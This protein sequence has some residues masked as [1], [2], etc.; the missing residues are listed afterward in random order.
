MK[1]S[2]LLGKGLLKVKKYSPEILLGTGI[3][4]MVGT[5]VV[6]CKA[7]TKLEAVTTEIAAEKEAFEEKLKA[8]EEV[9]AEG[10]EVDYTEADKKK[11]LL[12]VNTQQT[13]KLVKLYAPA[14]IL[15]AASIACILASYGIMKKRYLGVLAAYKSLD[16][17][18]K[19]YKAKV[20]AKYGEEAE[21]E[22]RRT[23]LEDIIKEGEEKGYEGNPKKH[24]VYSPYSR[25]Y[26]ETCTC[27]TDDFE[28]NRAFLH[29]TQCQMN[30][31]LKSQG[32]LYLN[33]VYDALGLA[34]SKEGA[35]VGWIL[36]GEGDSFVDFGVF[37]GNSSVTRAFVNGWEHSIL[38]DFN[39]DGVIYD[40]I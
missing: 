13:M 1:F 4:G 15:G 12:I 34:R 3:V 37:D 21:A 25:F 20:V 28:Y 30:N 10:R 18:F 24:N 36:D 29:T 16:A 11:D 23:S 33:E 8:I 26:D 5:V 38:L 19:K 17:T 40:R 35:V 14:A 7:T 27:W 2:A 39:V 9:V 31:R 22:L 6:A 32:H